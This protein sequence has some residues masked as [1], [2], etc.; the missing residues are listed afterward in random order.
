MCQSP[1][2]CVSLRNMWELRDVY[3]HFFPEYFMG[4]GSYNVNTHITRTHTH[5]HTHTTTPHN[6]THRERHHTHH[7]RGRERGRGEHKP[8]HSLTHPHTGRQTHIDTL[9]ILTVTCTHTD[10]HKH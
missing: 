3:I 5:T 4:F 7:N 9:Y 10:T 2:R 8:T 6:H 1:Y